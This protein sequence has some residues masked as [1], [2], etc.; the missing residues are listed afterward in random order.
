[1]LSV[2]EDHTD[3]MKLFLDQIIIHLHTETDIKIPWDP[4]MLEV[5]AS[6]KDISGW[7][8]DR[9]DFDETVDPEIL[10]TRNTGF[11]VRTGQSAS[12]ILIPT[13]ILQTITCR[14]Q[15]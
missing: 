15:R 10:R 11:S 13:W 12:L 6:S 7:E 5:L 14:Q 4:F 1:M 9:L 8:T 2:N 3:P